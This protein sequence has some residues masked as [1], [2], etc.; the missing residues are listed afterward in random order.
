MYP[1]YAAAASGD[2][3][4]ILATDASK[5]GF[6]AVLSQCDEGGVEQPIAFVSRA[7]LKNE[8][9]WG[10]T[11]LEA[12][13][14]VFGVKKFRHILWGSKFTILTDHRA[15]QY[16]ETCRDKSAR[17]ARWFEFLSAFQCSIVYKEG[18]QHANADGVSRNPLPATD[19]DAVA[20]QED[21]VLEAYVLEVSAAK[22]EGCS[23]QQLVAIAGQFACAEL[24]HITHSLGDALIQRPRADCTASA[25]A[26]TSPAWQHR[27]PRRLY[28]QNFV[29]PFCCYV[30]ASWTVS[31]MLT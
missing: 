25:G 22:A 27:S 19:A 3:P 4:F 30:V 12:G 31:R 23:R 17:L 29:S 21:A 28:V 2:R 11:D 26:G 24:A 14:I 1:D 18:P 8:R 6:G 16:L 13:A 5:E 10:I 20:E 9:N 15:L 7:T